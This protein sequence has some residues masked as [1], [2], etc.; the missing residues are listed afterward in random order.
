MSLNF[1]R[2]LSFF[3]TSN[4]KQCELRYAFLY[5]YKIIFCDGK[6]QSDRHHGRKF[7]LYPNISFVYNTIF[8]EQYNKIWTDG[9]QF[10]E[11]FLVYGSYSILKSS[12]GEWFMKRCLSDLQFHFTWNTTKFIFHYNVI[13]Y[14]EPICVM[15]CILLCI[16][17][18]I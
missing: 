16:L 12:H 3:K 9:A 2:P 7:I 6:P 5:Q 8:I 13:L 4:H 14:L 17:F 11:I 18:C 10:C 15:S 1:N